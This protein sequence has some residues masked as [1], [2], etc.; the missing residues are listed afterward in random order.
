MKRTSIVVLFCLCVLALCSLVLN[1]AKLAA[2]GPASAPIGSPA[3][4][5]TLD[6]GK[7]IAMKLTLI[8]AGKFLMGSPAGEKDR[9]PAEGPQHEVAI[10]KPFYMGVY[11]VTQAQYEA[12]MGKNPSVFKSAKNPVESVSWEDA[13]E[14]CKKLSQKTG[15]TVRLPTEAE[16]E[17]A[18]R[19]GT[20]TRFSFGDAD[21][22]LHK[23]GNYCDK[24]NT[25]GFQ[26]QDKAHDDG[27]DKTAPVGSYKP[28]PFG[29]YDIHGNVDEWCSDWYAESYAKAG[30]RDP[31]GPTT[32][33][34]YVVRGGCW[35]AP[36]VACSSA[37]RLPRL[38][39]RHAKSKA[40]AAMQKL[41]ATMV[42]MEFENQE[43]GLVIDYLR[44]ITDLPIHVKWRGNHPPHSG[45][46]QTQE[47]V[48]G[49]GSGHPPGRSGVGRR[50]ARVQDRQRRAHHHHHGGGPEGCGGRHEDDWFFL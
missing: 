8:P 36:G 4:Q 39:T 5:L 46:H 29:L 3:K 22:D 10:T 14:F 34:A 25:N 35:R 9:N 41:Q 50:E 19:A 20:K 13:V 6:L 44:E 31:Q 24:S 21:A 40:D 47:R 16:W 33:I 37:S 49:Q 43:L 23:Y 2:E 45:E 11:E 26:W 30:T 18:C 1:Q 17:Y 38:P 7:G 28:N 48:G 12:I 15:K 42:K 32:G 27:H